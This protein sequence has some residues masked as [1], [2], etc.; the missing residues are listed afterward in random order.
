MALFAIAAT[1]FAGQYA[2]LFTGMA[3]G[4]PPGL[5]SIVIQIQ[6][7]LTILIAVA[8]LGEKPSARQIAGALV[9]LAGLALIAATVGGDVSPAGFVLTLLAAA[10]WAVGN[11]LLRRA[12]KIDTLA[13]ISWLALLACPPLFALAFLI[14]G[15]A[16]VLHALT[17]PTWSGA[18]ALAYIAVLSTIVAFGI[19]GHLLK[20]HPAATVA[21]FALLVPVVGM[22]SAALV[23]GER[24]GPLRL[25]GTLLVLVGL[26]VVVL[27]RRLVP[28]RRRAVAHGEPE[29]PMSGGS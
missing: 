9:A 21:P 11:V 27:P 26:C 16:T 17:H 13:L 7:F 12:G 14:D 15:H 18:G 8:V 19:W 6:V 20:L 2:F 10:S 24:F 29:P 5:A 25:A 28:W 3:S 22:L 4:M 1:L 23:A